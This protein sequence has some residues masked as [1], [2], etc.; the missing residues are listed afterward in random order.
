MWG[1]DSWSKKP[2][3]SVL[4]RQPKILTVCMFLL[5]TKKRMHSS[6]AVLLVH[7]VSVVEEGE[8]VGR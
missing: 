8:E 5:I 7:F 1:V 6:F 2:E 4:T 3:N